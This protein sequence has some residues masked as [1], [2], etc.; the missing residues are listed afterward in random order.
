M[1]LR[2]SSNDDRAAGVFSGWPA[3]LCP[4]SAGLDSRFIAA[5][6][7]AVGYRNVRTFSY[8]RPRNHEAETAK[9]IAEQLGYS[10]TFV[11]FTA[12][13]QRAMFDDQQH[14]NALWERHD[15][16]TSVPFE[17]DWLA[18][19]TL[20]RSGVITEDAIIVNGQ[21]GDF[22]TGNH[23][24]AALMSTP[25]GESPE[26]RQ[27]RVLSAIT[28]K[29]YRLWGSLATPRND[30]TIAALLL[31]EAKA[32]GATFGDDEALHG[33]HEMLE[34]QDRQVKYV[35]SGQRTYDA[36]G[37]SWRLPLWDDEYVM[38]WRRAPASLKR[39]QNLYRRVLQADNWG[40]V[41]QNIPVNR[42]T[43][44]PAWIR[45]LRTATKL[46]IAPF[47]RS[48]W[49]AVER[50]AFAWWMDPLRVSAV[51]PYQRALFDQRGARHAVAHLTERYLAKHGV[52]LDD[53]GS[54][55]P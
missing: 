45:P 29:H 8:G 32:A 13:K 41:F 1:P 14:E 37:I 31:E 51:I 38:F 7:K 21:S 9:A 28:A 39:D 55:N 54:V 3:D 6:L 12:Q 44:T 49:H 27:A 20:Q 23:A 52:S 5:G 53:L 19:T 42:K 48:R 36:L 17:Q 30:A 4:L 43:I 18:I 15:A 35:I 2:S 11:P 25:V 26:A 40:G 33:I 10:W 46:A 50:R 22:I 34:Y 24:P 16:C 47:G